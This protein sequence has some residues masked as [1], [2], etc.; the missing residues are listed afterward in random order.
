[1]ANKKTKKEVESSTEERPDDVV[2]TDL[3]TFKFPVCGEEIKIKPWSFGT[4]SQNISPHIEEIFEVVDKSGIN[5]SN[6]QLLRTYIDPA[7]TDEEKKE[8]D[9][10]VGPANNTMMRLMT[11]VSS[12]IIDIIEVTT[13]MKRKDIENLNPTDVFYLCVHIYFINP[14]VLGNVFQPFVDISHEGL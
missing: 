14:T 13:N 10:L 4:Y 8:Y 3:E 12:Q 2:L 1:M 11:K 6:L 9:K 7:I 5:L